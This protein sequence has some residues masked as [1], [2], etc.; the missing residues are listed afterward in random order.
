MLLLHLYEEHMCIRMEFFVI[1]Q[2][3][4]S[5]GILISCHAGYI[6]LVLPE[7]LILK[8]CALLGIHLGVLV[9]CFP[10]LYGVL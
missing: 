6:N 2:L 1:F 8:Y 5:D 10:G 3:G 4:H 9:A 7:T